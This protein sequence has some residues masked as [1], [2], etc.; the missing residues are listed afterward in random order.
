MNMNRMIMD[1]Y[2]HRDKNAINTIKQSLSKDVKEMDT[3]FDEYLEIFSE[4]MT[5]ADDPKN[6]LWQAYRV[7]INEYNIMKQ[8]L[9]L[10]D[11]YLGML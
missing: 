10:A 3:F 5:A 9:K 6:P 2:Q 7:K 11:Y 4:K 1:A 8:N